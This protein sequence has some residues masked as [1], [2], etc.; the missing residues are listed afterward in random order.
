MPRQPYVL[1]PRATILLVFRNLGEA[2][3]ARRIMETA[4]AYGFS[5]KS[6]VFYPEL[7]SLLDEGFLNSV[8]V[9]PAALKNFPMEVPS[10]RAISLSHLTS[11]GLEEANSIRQKL[12]TFV[13]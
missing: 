10:S 5:I 3:S 11:K 7:R 4:N 12:S 13:W 2:A 9:T 6:G 8:T 1:S